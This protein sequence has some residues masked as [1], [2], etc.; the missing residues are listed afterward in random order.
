M[1]ELDPG[2]RNE[3]LCTGGHLHFNRRQA[4][5]SIGLAVFRKAAWSLAT[6]LRPIAWGITHADLDGSQT[7]TDTATED[8]LRADLARLAP[9]VYSEEGIPVFLACVN[10]VPVGPSHQVPK[11][12]LPPFSAALASTFHRNAQ[13]YQ[14]IRP[15]AVA[16]DVAPLIERGQAAKG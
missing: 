4:L 2:E 3:G 12:N 1:W 8:R 16:K 5:I 6:P 11:V 14:R 13:A 9:R 15:G 10:L 7:P